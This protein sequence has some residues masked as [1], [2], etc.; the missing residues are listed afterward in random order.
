MRGRVM[1]YVAMAYFG[2]LPI[3]SL[4]IGLISQK[5]GAPNTMLFQG[6]ISIIVGVS[7]A[8]FLRRERLKKE[9]LEQLE[10]AED[11]AVEGI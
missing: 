10:E 5:I 4:V 8:E 2:M 1:S 6:I 3:G 9:D 7:V 11:R